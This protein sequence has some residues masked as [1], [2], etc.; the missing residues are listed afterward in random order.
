MSQLVQQMKTTDETSSPQRHEQAVWA[1]LA[2]I[3]DGPDAYLHALITA[4]SQKAA[5]RDTTDARQEKTAHPALRDDAVTSAGAEAALNVIARLAQQMARARS[6]GEQEGIA[7]GSA[8]LGLI[9]GHLPAARRNA[10]PMADAR[11]QALLHDIALRLLVWAKRCQTIVEMAPAPAA[12]GDGT[13]GT[14][15][16]R[17]S[18]GIDEDRLWRIYTRSGRYHLC[19]P[20]CAHWPSDMLGALDRTGLHG[21]GEEQTSF[22]CSSPLCL[23]V[24]GDPQVLRG[25]CLAIVGSRQ[26]SDYGL[27]VTR[28]CAQAAAGTGLSVVTGG[29]MGV[30]GQ[31]NA[32]A[33]ELGYPTA[34]VFAGGL[35]HAGPSRNEWLFD[36]MRRTGGALISELPPW[37]VPRSFRFLERNRLIAALCEAVLVTQARYRS[38]ALNTASWMRRI[39]RPVIMV[40]GPITDPANGGCNAQIADGSDRRPLVLTRPDELCGLVREGFGHERREAAQ[41][42]LAFEHP[43]TY[44]RQA[45]DARETG[46]SAQRSDGSSRPSGRPPLLLEKEDALTA[47]IVAQLRSRRQNAAQIHAQLLASRPTATVPDVLTRLARLEAEGIISVDEAGRAS[48]IARPLAFRRRE[49]PSRARQR[50]EPKPRPTAEAKTDRAALLG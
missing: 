40:P 9:F 18:A 37:I 15:G 41:L 30:D 46:E 17:P 33:C 28:R 14:V 24:D 48:L 6:R 38:G 1:Q 11:G 50:P 5:A 13:R 2:Q 27:T 16:D 36:R 23:W 44:G 22:D 34:A 39:G 43:I 47:A 4:L 45:P 26:A 10:G 19:H 29:A 3:A 49:D 42:Q 12:S 20:G 35:D 7:R 8:L 32:G 21:N 31:A 25:E